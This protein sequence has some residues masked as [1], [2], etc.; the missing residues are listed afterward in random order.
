[1]QT[2]SKAIQRNWLPQDFKVTSWEQLEPWFENLA[3]R[4]LDNEA[5]LMNWLKDSSE[6]EAIL[7]E[8]LAWR[9]I[10]MSCDTQ[11]KELAENFNYFIAHISPKISEY[12]NKLLQKYWDC[13]F[14]AALDP[15]DFKTHNLRVQKELELFRKENIP[16]KSEVEIKA[17]EYDAITGAATIQYEGKELTL[18]QASAYLE[19]PQREV[20]EKVWRL[21]AERRLQDAAKLDNLMNELI[22]LRTKIAKNAG[23]ASY[24]AYKFRELGRF[25]YTPDTCRA[26]HNAIEIAV[27]P[28]AEKLIQLRKQRLNL[29]RLR[30]WDLS[31]DIWGEQ[32]LQP[33]S[34]AEELIEKAIA[35]LRKIN[36]AYGQLLET[37]RQMNHLDLA[38][39]KGKAPGGYNYPL[40]ETGIPF[41]FM[42]AVGTQNDLT[43]IIHEA[44]HAVHAFL[45]KDLSLNTFK[46]TPSEVAELASMSMELISMPYWNVFY[47]NEED[48]RRAQIQQITR[49]LT[50]LPW[51]ATVD[52]F[53]WWIYDHPSH[54]PIERNSIWLDYYKRFHGE[55]VDWTGLDHIRRYQ[56]QRQ[57]HIYTVPFYYIEYGFAQLGALQIWKSYTQDP[58]KTLLHYEA[59]L[60]LGY[61]RS[62]TE[63]YTTAGVDFSFTP[64]SI[65]ELVNF[66]ESQL[67]KLGV[68]I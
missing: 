11:N 24:S 60:R 31:V 58:E 51:I 63:I 45:T 8:D 40:Y 56:W 3:N 14:R 15:E 34:S 22:Q 48:L 30:P 62:I 47:E 28:L 37:M 68:E 61:K 2:I 41:I 50:T 32:P 9:Y 13:P 20:R 67:Q 23:F 18:Q 1:M 52:A 59:A 55:G 46:D 12:E 21:M 7:Q 6:L 64:D 43:T 33:F 66:V 35:T 44:G 39:R 27:K 54:T 38:S 16:L 17:Q 29:Q 49:S 4:N 5:D 19:K 26:F 57:L 65:S 53:Q 10:K 36:P 42:N 25:D